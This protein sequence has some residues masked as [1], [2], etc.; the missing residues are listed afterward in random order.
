MHWFRLKSISWPKRPL[1]LLR[2]PR[3]AW[4]FFVA[5][6]GLLY[7]KVWLP[8]TG[9]GI[10][11]VFRELTD[12]YCPGCGITRALVSLLSLDFYQSF[13]WNPLIPFLL[14]LYIAYAI[15]QRKQLRWTS[16]LVMAVMLTTT[17]LFGIAR[18]IPALDW[19]APTFVGA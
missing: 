19:L 14:L 11:C 8:L 3:L 16:G 17:V 15:A 9:F 5:V 7:L 1:Q 12:W 6:G 4:G 18:N 2:N 10:P 13:R